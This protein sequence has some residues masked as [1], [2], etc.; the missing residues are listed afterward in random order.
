MHVSFSMMYVLKKGWRNPA[1]L[2]PK[3]VIISTEMV[4]QEE[5]SR[6]AI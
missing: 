4:I 2:F 3:M 6:I 5:E 1:L